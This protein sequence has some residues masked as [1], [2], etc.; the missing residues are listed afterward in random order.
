M[1]MNMHEI[2]ARTSLCLFLFFFVCVN[3]RETSINYFVVVTR[4]F[5]R[6]CFFILFS[7]AHLTCVNILSFGL[8][9]CLCLSRVTLRAEAFHISTKKQ[10]C[11]KGLSSHVN[12]ACVNIPSSWSIVHEWELNIPSL[13]LFLSLSQAR[14]GTS[15]VQF[16]LVLEL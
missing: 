1:C 4:Q 2:S 6:V 13:S 16:L 12:L 7:F 10:G 11:I 3:T 15:L 5:A 8:F 14:A 9:F